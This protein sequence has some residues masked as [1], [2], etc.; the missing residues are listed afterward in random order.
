MDSD[1]R[2]TKKDRSRVIFTSL[3]AKSATIPALLRTWHVDPSSLTYVGSS[4]VTVRGEKHARPYTSA[5]NPVH[6][7]S[8]RWTQKR[9]PPRSSSGQTPRFIGPKT[10]SLGENKNQN[11]NTQFE[12]GC[13]HRVMYGFWVHH[14]VSLLRPPPVIALHCEAAGL[15]RLVPNR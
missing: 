6:A 15:P 12:V 14:E 9:P 2:S 11:Q 7:C 13:K 3:Y 10:K 4:R 1:L 5:A 8:H